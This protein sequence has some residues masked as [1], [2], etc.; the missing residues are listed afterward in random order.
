MYGMFFEHNG[1]GWRFPTEAEVE[2]ELIGL[3]SVL[4]WTWTKEKMADDDYTSDYD[5]ILVRDVK[6]A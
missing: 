4:G 5:V 6:N 3:P 1:F 2:Q